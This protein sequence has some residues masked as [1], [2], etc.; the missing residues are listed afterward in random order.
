[1]FLYNDTEIFTN[2]MKIKR[3]K[4]TK[5]QPQTLANRLPVGGCFLY[6]FRPAIKIAEKFLS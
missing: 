6:C 1:M 4:L 2:S 5:M 3:K